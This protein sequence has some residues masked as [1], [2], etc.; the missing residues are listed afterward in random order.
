MI[1]LKKLRKTV[2]T[3]DFRLVY[4]HYVEKRTNMIESEYRNL[5][6]ILNTNSQTSEISQ[7]VNA[8]IKSKTSLQDFT[9]KVCDYFLR[10]LYVIMNSFDDNHI[11]INSCIN[12]ALNYATAEYLALSIVRC[13]S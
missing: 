13:I 1:P 3:E 10:I 11:S 7:Q 2:I 12:D 8:E 9:D 4:S 5:I 6:G